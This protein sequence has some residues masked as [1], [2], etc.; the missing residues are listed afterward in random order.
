MDSRPVGVKLL[1]SSSCQRRVLIKVTLTLPD[2]AGR[3]A[4]PLV[5]GIKV[6]DP[7]NLVLVTVSH[8]EVRQGG[9]KKTSSV[10]KGANFVPIPP[11]E[12]MF[13]RHFA[14]KGFSGASVD[15]K[16]LPCKTHLVIIL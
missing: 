7:P 4:R 3:K 5:R 16:R 6:S 9:K 12:R 1:L 11:H 8:E 10:L 2:R 13:S 14:L 15:K